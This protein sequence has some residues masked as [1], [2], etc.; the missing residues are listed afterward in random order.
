VHGEEAS[1]GSMN[2]EGDGRCSPSVWVIAEALH[3]C[4]ATEGGPKMDHRYE[5]SVGR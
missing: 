1:S 5:A 4:I 2:E 3:F